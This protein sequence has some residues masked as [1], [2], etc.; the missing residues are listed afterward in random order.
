MCVCFKK[1]IKDHLNARG[2]HRSASVLDEE[3][4]IS[5][6]EMASNSK[7]RFNTS[8]LPSPDFSSRF[9]DPSQ[10]ENPA[11]LEQTNP[12]T[13]ASASYSP[14]FQGNRSWKNKRRCVQ[15]ISITDSNALESMKEKSVASGLNS[16]CMSH[17]ID[18]NRPTS[19]ISPNHGLRIVLRLVSKI[20]GGGREN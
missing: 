19:P 3:L 13:V 11:S 14:V 18:Q 15:H 1:V 10:M 9:I 4:G 20:K 17:N 2:L 8:H 12:Y 6:V 16:S 5:S 7:S